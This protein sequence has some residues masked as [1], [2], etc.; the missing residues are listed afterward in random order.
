MTTH[1]SPAMRFL[2]LLAAVAGFAFICTPIFLSAKTSVTPPPTTV[3]ATPD[4]W[5]AKL[6]PLVYAVTRQG[7]TEQP[8][9]GS[10]LHETRKGTYVTADCGE[11]VFRSETKYDSGTGWP[12]FYAP[13]KGAVIEKPDNSEGLERTEV[14]GSK[15]GTHLGHVFDDGPQPTGLRYCINSAALLFIPDE[16]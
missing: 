16:K 11:P 15:C 10:L 3:S 2:I 7:G 14:V 9:T 6:S 4:S 12:S 1:T 5:K 8:F 13:I